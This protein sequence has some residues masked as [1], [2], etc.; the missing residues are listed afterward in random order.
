MSTTISFK[1]STFGLLLA[2]ALALLA[3]CSDRQ[4]PA[5]PAAPAS[6]ATA[7]PVATADEAALV[8]R[9]EYLARAG[10]CMACHSVVG[11]APYSGGLAI[12]S[13]VGT[14]YSTNITPDKT[15]GIGH[16]SEQ[17]F[18]DAVRR[19]VR[20]DG[21][22]LYPAMPYPDYVKT[23]DEDM[24]ALY[25]YFTKGVKPSAE[26]PPETALS[27]P[28][29]MRWGMGVWNM[30]FAENEPFVAPAGATGELARGAYLVQ[31]LGHCGSC[32]T[33]R[34]VAMN[35]KAFDDGSASFL[36][37]GELNDW[38]VPA[39]RGL[40]HWTR[41]EIVDYLATGRNAKAAVAGEMTSV[42]ANSTS[43]LNDADLNAIAVYLQSLTPAKP[44]AQPDEAANQATTAKLTAATGLGEGQRLYIDNCVACHFVDGRGA[45]R[46]FPRVDGASIV[47][48]DNPT[49]LVQVI[50]GGAQTPSTARGP[51]VL[52][53]PGFAE[54]L[55]DQE[56]A[57][58][59]TFV[60][61][62]WSNKAGAV[63][64]SQVAKARK[65]L[66]DE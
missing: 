12:K 26:R 51:A 52:P 33:P 24:H 4:G 8:E 57:D 15:A 34:G 20:A 58:L 9:G 32:H 29:S 10:D 21:Q 40:P 5:T 44:A 27:F 35:Q 18:A 30:A 64:A 13:G 65:A 17:Q 60:R 25:V 63:S 23:T 48:A 2:G 42:V 49:A 28:F 55:S 16:Y 53:M 37:G 54:R 59:A 1:T 7:A 62:G 50:L 47:N 61:S 22:H 38:H 43:H 3:G 19:G 31:G 14:I 39:L 6:D 45:P 36:A 41:E 46:V 56:V 11:K 66:H